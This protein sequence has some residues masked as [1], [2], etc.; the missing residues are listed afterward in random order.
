MIIRAI[1]LLLAAGGTL[2]GQVV[3]FDGSLGTA[4]SDQGWPFIAD[5]ISSNSVTEI[6]SAGFTTVDTRTP[7][8]ERAGYFS[9][10]PILQ[11]FNHPDMPVTDRI[12]GYSIRFDVRITDENHV[13]GVGGDDNGDGLADRAGF[14]V[15]SISE[16]LAGIELAFWEDRMWAQEDD[17][18]A[19]SDLFTQAEGADFDT[20]DSILQYELNVLGSLYQ[21][22][23]GGG[24]APL[25]QGAL[26]NYSNF[27]G[28]IDPYELPS[29]LFLGDNTTRAEA[30]FE[31]AHIQID[32]V[33]AAA[34]QAD[35]LVAAIVSATNPP[36]FDLTDDGQVNL[37][38]LST[39]L[40]V[41]GEFYLGAGRSF[42]AGDANLD[43]AVDGQDF[44][45]WNNNKFM[46]TAAWTAGDF[47]ADGSVDGAD[48]LI[49]NNNKFQSS[50]ALLVPEPKT[51]AMW[52]LG[53][54]LF[55]ARRTKF[56]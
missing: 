25:L 6:A 17:S 31:I 34:A 55:A 53:C 35:A 37:D 46:S 26:R 20:T 24:V 42:L 16:D 18:Q 56:W 49:W 1:C 30:E 15:I 23:P 12:P 54:L 13:E 19:A 45:I 50:D 51:I 29:F 43:G 38:D 40:N 4:P 33:T 36:H 44:L 47:N 14:S 39:W 21:V 52:F 28:S 2:S 10:D 41:A 3:L 9:S 7:M 22:I 11:I 5:P 8:S 27:V 48:F 32:S